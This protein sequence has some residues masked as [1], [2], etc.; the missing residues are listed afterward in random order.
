MYGSTMGAPIGY[1]LRIQSELD[2]A[3]RAHPLHES[4]P[5]PVAIGPRSRA[6]QLALPI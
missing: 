5:E 1:Q 4:T 6:G 2:A 3:R